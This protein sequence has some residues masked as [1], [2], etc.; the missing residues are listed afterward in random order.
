MPSDDYSTVSRGALKIKGV[1]GS[2]VDKHKKK[3]KKP[4]DESPA[5]QEAQASRSEDVDLPESSN[6]DEE[7]RLNDI[8]REEDSKVEQVEGSGDAS[9]TE[10][11]RRF[12]ERRRRMVSSS[13]A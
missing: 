13:H 3:K 6:I 9:K 8:L 7:G 11:E 1:Q 10:A 5:A 2:K 12:D 4:K